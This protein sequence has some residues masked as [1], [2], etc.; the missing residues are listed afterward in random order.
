MFQRTIQIIVIGLAF[1]TSAAYE[2]RLVRKS[3]SPTGAIENAEG[4]SFMQVEVTRA[5]DLLAELESKVQNQ[6]LDPSAVQVIKDLVDKELLPDLHNSHDIAQKTID[7]N[8]DNIKKTNDASD[9]NQKKIK[10]T[11]E[12]ITG[13]ARTTHADCREEEIQKEGHKNGRCGELDTFLEAIK[14][15]AAKPK[16]R[17]AMVKYVE[18]T[19]SYMC[20]LGPEASA[21]DEAC[22]QAEKEHAEHQADCNKKQAAFELDF[23]TW[24]TQLVDE[25]T[26]LNTAYD[27]AVQVWKDHVDVTAKLVSK[28]KVEYKALHKIKC[29]TDIWEAH[30]DDKPGADV[31]DKCKNNEADDSAMDVDPGKPADKQECDLTPVE[32]YPGTTKFPEVEYSKFAKYA[33]E[34]LECPTNG[35]GTTA[36]PT[37]AAPTT[38][39]PTTTTAA[40]TTTTVAPTTT[41]AAP[42]TVAPTTDM[43]LEGL[44]CCRFDGWKARN[45]GYRTIESCKQI[46]RDTTDCIA[47]DVARPRGEN[48]DCYTFYGEGNNFNLQCGTNNQHE[49]CFRKT[50]DEGKAPCSDPNSEAAKTSAPHMIMVGNGCCRFDG[51]KATNHGYKTETECQE[52]CVKEADCVAADLA[53]PRGETYD[54]YTFYGNANSNFKTQ[55]GTTNPDEICYRNSA[56]IDVGFST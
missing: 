17:D 43:K 19:S 29:Y 23:C 46:C 10:T 36:A 56:H 50:V 51:W 52:I 33:V 45:H 15:P 40:P 49:Q 2:G 38:A 48:Y 8:L 7:K 41:T 22:K 24:R 32:T 6:A 3:V 27:D 31:Y 37:T 20:P 13:K 53:R 14:S 9:Q 28:W 35:K 39:A 26:F 11:V 42:T 18:S 54:C 30:S 21:L 25:C 55:C 5:E 47:A 1:Q 34:P 12:A 4:E 16:G 44:G